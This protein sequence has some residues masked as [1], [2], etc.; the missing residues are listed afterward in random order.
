MVMISIYLN[1]TE[2][3]CKQKSRTKLIKTLL[4]SKY[5]NNSAH[6][7][8]TQRKESQIVSNLQNENLFVLI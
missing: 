5:L 7:T 8:L 3:E 2:F 4:H 6:I 1:T